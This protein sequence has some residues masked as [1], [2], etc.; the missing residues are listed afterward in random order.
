MAGSGVFPKTPTLDIIYQGD[1]NTIQSVIAGVLSTYYGTSLLSS[2]LSGNPVVTAA[3]WDLLRQDINRCYKHITGTNSSIND[4]DIASIVL[5][6]DA[7]AYKTAADYCETNKASV[8][9]SQLTSTVSSTSKTSTWNGTFRLYNRYVWNSEAEANYWFNLGGYFSVDVSGANSTGTSKDND[10]Q[11]NILNAIPTQVY[12]RSNW[13]SGTNIDVYE[14]GNVGVYGENYCRIYCQKVSTT[15]L[16]IYVII[17]DADTGDQTGIGPAV[18]ENVNTDVFASIT[19]YSSIDAIVAAG[20]TEIPVENF[21]GIVGAFNLNITSNQSEPIDLRALAVSAGWNQS[22]YVNATISN[23]V[24][25][26]SNTTVSPAITISGSFPNGVRLINNGYVI[27]MGGRGGDSMNVGSPGGTALNVGTAATIQN[28]GTIAGGGG[29]GGAGTYWV[30]NGINRSVAGSGGG[31]GFTAAAGGTGADSQGYG[32]PSADTNSD[33]IYESGG[34]SRNFGWGGRASSP[35]G[36]GGNWGQAGDAG[37]T[38]DGVY[39]Q[40]GYAGGAA[41]AAVV[42]NGN[43]TWEATGTRLGPIS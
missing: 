14:Y 41:G 30:W 19:V 5:A 33:T 35:G 38:V 10:W 27:G 15:R 36:K 37:G 22:A 7:N 1:Y 31:S 3:Q 18:D 34:A 8:H 13:V 21:D 17:N 43:I 11:N 16:D 32:N 4:V 40:S 12:S 28:N 25:V 6:G 26:S 24:Y 23:G 39:D 42:G 9:P 2:Q 29:G 20:L